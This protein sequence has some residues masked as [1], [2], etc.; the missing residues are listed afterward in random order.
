MHR[1]E[2]A[3]GGKSAI[4]DRISTFSQVPNVKPDS[5]YGSDLSSHN[6]GLAHL[7]EQWLCKPQVKGSNPLSSTVGYGGISA[8]CME[9][10]PYRCPSS[11]QS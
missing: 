6:G 10:T 7:V 8:D 9:G 11:R 5:E 3:F 1:P 2:R 4:L